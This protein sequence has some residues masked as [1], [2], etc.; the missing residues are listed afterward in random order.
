MY[1]LALRPISNTP[2]SIPADF[3][4]VSVLRWPQGS[5]VSSTQPTSFTFKQNRSLNYVGIGTGLSKWPIINPANG[6]YNWLELDAW[7]IANDAYGRTVSFTMH[8]NPSWC[9]TVT[10]L[11]SNVNQG[12]DINYGQGACGPIA[13]ASLG[14][15]STFVQLVINRYN[16]AS[17]G[18]FSSNKLRVSSIQAGN[19]PKFD[20]GLNVI[21]NSGYIGT[22]SGLLTDVTTGHTGTVTS[23]NDA[24]R[25]ITLTGC[26]GAFTLGGSV[27]SS[28]FTGVVSSNFNGLSYQFGGTYADLAAYIR[29]CR[30]GRDASDTR[31]KIIGPAFG[32]GDTVSVISSV[33]SASDGAGGVGGDHIDYHGYNPYNY[34][35]Q[36]HKGPTSSLNI[37]K[38][39][40]D[41]TTISNKPICFTEFGAS[42]PIA[43]D[44]DGLLSVRS[45]IIS[46]TKGVKLI[47]VY[48]WDAGFFPNSSASRLNLEKLASLAGKTIDRMFE[49][50][51]TG[52]L[53]ISFNDGST[54]TI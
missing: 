10:G 17:G 25:K 38:L 2:I 21:L 52:E 26:N 11:Y 51:N 30:L 48:S 44:E 42:M 41:I 31:V 39:I 49:D 34:Y 7:V 27:T 3:L 29:Q 8:G 28:G 18:V 4:A 1:L 43:G 14:E 6:V 15:I 45:M 35:S 53:Y 22:P 5:P 54:M 9:K 19:E 46:L 24:N 23:F 50:Q 47:N 32:Y 13:S 37:E 40:R 16:F 36:F 33:L 20:N 12:V